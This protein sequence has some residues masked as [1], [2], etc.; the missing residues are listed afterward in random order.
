[1]IKFIEII[2][3]PLLLFVLSLHEYILGYT[4]VSIFLLLV[5]FF[6]L[7]VNLMTNK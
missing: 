3:V 6:R 1:M 4:S 2:E 5:G 7:A